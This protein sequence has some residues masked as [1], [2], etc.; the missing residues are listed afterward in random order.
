MT[1]L[2]Q[3]TQRAGFAEGMDLGVAYLL[4][5]GMR[6][7]AVAQKV[8]LVSGRKESQSWKEVSGDSLPPIFRTFREVLAKQLTK[9]FE[10]DTTPNKHVLLALKINPSVNTN[11]D[12]PQLKGKAAKAEL[13]QAEYTR[14]LRRQAIFLK[15]RSS[16]DAATIAAAAAARAAAAT[17][18]APTPAPVAA[19]APTPAPA[20]APTPA[21]VAAAAAA[22]EAAPAVKRQRTGLLGAVMAQ[23]Q[24]A[25]PEGDD[26]S[27]EIDKAVQ[28]EINNF[29][30]ISTRI[31]AEGLSNKYFGGSQLFNLHEFWADHKK[32]LPLHFGAYVAEVGCKKA[33]AANVESVFFLPERAGTSSRRRPRVL[34][35]PCF[36][37]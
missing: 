22:P 31:L 11:P 15:Q 20:A 4:V 1:L 21:P 7:E 24:T 18:A 2:V 28:S 36:S 35:P 9:R 29:D 27:S 14:A 25:Q 8:E 17:A 3:D 30:M 19:A 5:N 12:S 32:S 10:L 33:A 34:S 23:Q 6:D 13:M 16:A 26:T 37:A